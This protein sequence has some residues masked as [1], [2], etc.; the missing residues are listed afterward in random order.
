M[1]VLDTSDFISDYAVP[2]LKLALAC[3]PLIIIIGMLIFAREDEEEEKA[4]LELQ[5]KLG[6]CKK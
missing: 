2:F 4:K 6:S 3:S 5:K 1:S